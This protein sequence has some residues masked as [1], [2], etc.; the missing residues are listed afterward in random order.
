MTADKAQTILNANNID[1][2]L[3]VTTPTGD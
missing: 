3:L 1:N 2:E